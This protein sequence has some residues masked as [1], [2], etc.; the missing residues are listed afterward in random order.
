MRPVIVQCVVFFGVLGIL[1]LVIMKLVPE[2]PTAAERFERSCAPLYA[3]ARSSHDSLLVSLHRGSL[4]HYTCGELDRR[5]R[6]V[7]GG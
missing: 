6:I 4:E 3:Q 7:E 2:G 1:W 5:R